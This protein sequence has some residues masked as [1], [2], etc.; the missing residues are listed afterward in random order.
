MRRFFF[1]KAIGTVVVFAVLGIVLFLK[2][3]L[4]LF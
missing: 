2:H 1:G 4:H 3:V